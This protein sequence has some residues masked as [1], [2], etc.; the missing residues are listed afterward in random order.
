MKLQNLKTI[1]IGR[2]TIYFEKID[3]TQKEI[4]RRVENKTIKNGELI[5]AQIQTNGIRNT[6]KNMVYK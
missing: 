5:L 6:W 4:L 3:S 1:Y 2:N